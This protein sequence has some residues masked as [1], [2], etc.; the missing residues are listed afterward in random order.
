MLKNVLFH[1]IDSAIATN[2]AINC[3]ESNTVT[4]VEEAREGRDNVKL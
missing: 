3:L 2:A 4:M 1:P